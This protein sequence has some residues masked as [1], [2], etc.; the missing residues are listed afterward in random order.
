M[1]DINID[2]LLYE[3]LQ[4]HIVVDYKS[5]IHQKVIFYLLKSDVQHNIKNINLADLVDKLIFWYQN[6]FDCHTD[7]SVLTSDNLNK[8]VKFLVHIKKDLEYI[9]ELKEKE[10][11]TKTDD[12]AIKDFIDLI[13]Q[14]LQKIFPL[15]FLYC[16]EFFKWVWNKKIAVLES[17]HH[18]VPPV[19]KFAKEI[20]SSLYKNTVNNK[21]GHTVFN[22][23]FNIANVDQI[24]N[25]AFQHLQDALSACYEAF[26]YLENNP[27]INEVILK[28]QNSYYRRLQHT[29]ILEN[30]YLSES[31]GEGSTRSVVV[32]RKN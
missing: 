13:S 9:Y 17:Y 27:Q 15:N 14:R 11:I 8:F 23:N 18:S 6:Q 3:C 25:S 31:R 20:Q 10:S 32:L 1:N 21:A 7:A 28:P 16:I 19:G 29:T 22:H 30:G 4:Y 24:D 2:T 5:S 26:I 12:M